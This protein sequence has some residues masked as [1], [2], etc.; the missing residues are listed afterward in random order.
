M[1]FGGRASN[2]ALD[3]Y[4][5]AVVEKLVHGDMRRMPAKGALMFFVYESRGREGE[6]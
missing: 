5:A 6:G 4:D 2:P 3:V 1:T